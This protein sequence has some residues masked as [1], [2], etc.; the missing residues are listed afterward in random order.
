MTDRLYYTDAYLREFDATVTRVGRRERD[1]LVTLD[2]TAFYPTSGGQPFDVGTLGARRVL[3]VIDE[4]DGSISHVVEESTPGGAPLQIGDPLHGTID[5]P[6][7]F[8]H[9]QQHTGQHVLSAAFER[10]AGGRTVSFHLGAAS[11]TIDLAREV[12]PSEMAAAENEANRVVW[13]DH[14]VSI[15]F[16]GAEEAASLPLRKE[17]SRG[18]TLRLIDV[19]QFDLS[20]CGGTHVSRTG[21]IGIIAVAAS[22]RFKGGSRIEFVCGGRA[23]ARFR[24]LRDSVASV[25]RLLSAG[26]DDLP[27]TVERLQAEAKEHK[28]AV[29]GLQTELARYRAEEL[30][31][32]PE[33]IRLKRS[34]AA[35]EAPLVRLVARAI[36]ADANGLKALAT[37]VSRKPG[38]VVVLVSTGRPALAIVSRSPEVSL[39]ASAVLTALLA[40]FGGR[41]GG[42]PDVAQGGGLDGTSDEILAAARATLLA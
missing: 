14:P 24:S 39:D 30:A 19:D 15:R 16:V 12:S 11:A 32:S 28:R 20:A 7:R 22:E 4:D 35:S 27:A 26:G 13:D 33:E 23:L 18:G 6:R 37:A 5:W 1:V 31:S 38:Y 40:T 29:A 21:A 2:R 3:D 17:P 8:D 36:D 25:G 10:V 9:M 34:D 41:G 42:R